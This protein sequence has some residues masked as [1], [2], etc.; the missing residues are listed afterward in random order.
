MRPEDDA[1]DDVTICPVPS[2]LY[3]FFGWSKGV[4]MIRKMI[5]SFQRL[6][7]FLM[8][9]SK[10]DTIELKSSVHSWVLSLKIDINVEKDG[11]F[12]FFF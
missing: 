6:P 2:Q 1:V 4:A 8:C 9:C 10:S 12:Q 5:R 11:E 3:P 7:A